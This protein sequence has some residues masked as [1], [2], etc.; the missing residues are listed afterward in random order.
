MP[1]TQEQAYCIAICGISAGNKPSIRIQKATYCSMHNRQSQNIHSAT[2]PQDQY[3]ILYRAE[4]CH[5]ERH[6]EINQEAVK[7]RQHDKLLA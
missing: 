1:Y 5:Q 2:A 4:E 3:I 6:T 7:Y